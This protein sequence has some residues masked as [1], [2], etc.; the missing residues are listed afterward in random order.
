MQNDLAQPAPFLTV[1]I[2]TRERCE[3]LHSALKTVCEQDLP[4]VEFIVSDNVSEDDTANVVRG[5]NDA[6]LTYIRTQRRLSMTG[7]YNFALSHA[8][9]TYVTILGDDDGF[10]PGALSV[11]AKWARTTGADAI[12]WREAAYYWPTHSLVERRNLLQLP[13]LDLNWNVSASAAFTATKWSF[14]RWNVLP[15]IYGGLVKRDLMNKLRDKTGDYLLSHI[16]DVYSAIAICSIIE[17]YIYTEYPFSTFGFSG[18]SM[19]STYHSSW[20]G[21]RTST[22]DTFSVFLQENTTT[23]HLAF[24]VGDMRLENAAIIDCLYRV[25]D[26]LFEGRLFLP[27]SVWLYRLLREA[28]L[29]SEPLRSEMLSRIETIARQRRRLWFV[30]SLLRLSAAKNALNQAGKTAIDQPA[31]GGEA[32]IEGAALNIDCA[33]FGLTDIYG[34]C[35]LVAK[36]RPLPSTIPTFRSAGLRQLL[37]LRGL[38]ARWAS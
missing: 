7:N 19:A 17:K 3:T 11:L 36:V 6:R 21:G 34:A 9:G 31:S 18:K 12:S 28:S 1:I 23:P 29:I 37:G 20:S 38:K 8:R 33:R 30:N 4:E 32:L 26:A 25:K 16:P 35:D 14:L 13:L 15:I 22:S 27:D 24:P 2:P 5:F 10:I